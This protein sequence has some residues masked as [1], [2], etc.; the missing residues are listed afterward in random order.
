MLV[1]IVLV[2]VLSTTI[3]ATVGFGFALLSV[4]V[5]LW[6]NVSI[7]AVLA[8]V[9]ICAA[10]QTILGTVKYRKHIKWKPVLFQSALRFIGLPIGII[11]LTY[12]IALGQDRI[13]QFVGLSLLLILLLQWA[14][15]LEPRKEVHWIWSAIAGFSS[16]LIGGLVA[17]SG[18]PVVLYAQAHRWTSKQMRVFIWANLSVASPFML[19]LL[20]LKFGNEVVWPTLFGLAIVPLLFF[21][22]KLGLTLGKQLPRRR[23]RVA[24]LV[25]LTIIAVW[26]LVSPIVL[27]SQ[28]SA[29]AQQT[30]S[31][32]TDEPVVPAPDLPPR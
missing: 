14:V 1:L 3:Q 2:L 18:P 25:L 15:K 17:M 19:L 24:V 29:A 9:T 16:G 4:P 22:S 26:S 10:V 32:S 12:L 13:K 28:Q 31:L 6:M 8:L 30:S 5:L 11:L 23:L 21:G 7:P 27:P 20:Y